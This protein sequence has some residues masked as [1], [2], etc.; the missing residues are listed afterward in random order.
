MEVDRYGVKACNAIYCVQHVALWGGEASI[1]QAEV[2][3]DV[4][5]GD[6]SVSSGPIEFHD[7]TIGDLGA[8]G[9]LSEGKS[10]DGQPLQPVRFEVNSTSSVHP[11]DASYLVAVVANVKR[12]VAAV[13]FSYGVGLG[14]EYTPSP[15]FLLEAALAGA[16]ALGWKA[17]MGRIL[18]GGEVEPAT[19]RLALPAWPD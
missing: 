16:T 15:A 10:A 7:K 13:D 3:F 17:I 19:Y 18:S 1:G 14:Q 9:L 6:V 12:T 2:E 8:S 11:E 5:T 4:M